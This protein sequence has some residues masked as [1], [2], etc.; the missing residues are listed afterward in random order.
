MSSSRSRRV[1]QFI[2]QT[3][4][5]SFTTLFLEVQLRVQSNPV[6][7]IKEAFCALLPLVTLQCALGKPERCRQQKFA[8]YSECVFLSVKNQ[9]LIK[10]YHAN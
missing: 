3:K 2:V 7:L 5:R 8:I 10:T 4:G 6:L 1:S 9:L